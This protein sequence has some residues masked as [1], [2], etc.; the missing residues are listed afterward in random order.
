MTVFNRKQINP[1]RIAKYRQKENIFISNLKF[2][3][4]SWPHDKTAGQAPKPQYLTQSTKGNVATTQ[5]H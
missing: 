2:N 4:N 5:S 3:P 1:Q